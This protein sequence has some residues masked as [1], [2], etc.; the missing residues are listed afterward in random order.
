MQ[1]WNDIAPILVTEQ[2]LNATKTKNEKF[3]QLFFPLQCY[4]MCTVFQL[5]IIIACFALLR[6]IS[7]YLCSSGA[8]HYDCIINLTCRLFKDKRTFH[9]KYEFFPSFL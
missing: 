2:R 4:S 5:T 9:W 8:M 3:L 7:T 1:S 6:Q